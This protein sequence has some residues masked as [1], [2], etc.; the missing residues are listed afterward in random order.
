MGTGSLEGGNAGLMQGKCSL[1]LGLMD[2]GERW[3]DGEN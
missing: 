2:V 3:G 1:K